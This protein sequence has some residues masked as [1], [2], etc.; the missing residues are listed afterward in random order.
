M[1]QSEKMWDRWK[2]PGKQLAHAVGI[3]DSFFTMQ[4]MVADVASN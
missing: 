2:G 3:Y 1:S 4:T